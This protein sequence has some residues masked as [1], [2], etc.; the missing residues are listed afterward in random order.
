MK[1]TMTL[2]VVALC[3][4]IVPVSANAACGS[5]GAA[6]L[7]NS[8]KLPILTQ[9]ELGFPV[10]I[11][12]ANPG[13][14][15]LWHVI[16]TNSAD[17]STFNDTFD[18][19]HSDGTEF[20]SAFLA[21]A[22]GNVCVGVWKQTG[23]RSVS[24]HHVGWLFNPSTPTATATNTFTLDE[25]INVS[26]DGMSYSGSFTFKVWELNGS[27]TPVEVTGTIA[28]TRITTN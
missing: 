23:L 4:L 5:F 16:Y 8:I 7:K 18:T 21:P 24:L 25:E 19:W 6:G 3:L 22:G 10:P 26:A 2:A 27:P 12:G 20:E 13:I 1:R 15:G 14:V 28:A 11:V 9:A 17:Q